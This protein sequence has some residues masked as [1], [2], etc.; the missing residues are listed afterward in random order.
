MKDNKTVTVSARI[1]L[2][3][4]RK[5]KAIASKA[6]KTV[7]EIIRDLIITKNILQEKLK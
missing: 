1:E 3:D 7:S 2:D 6:G 5:I 4:Y